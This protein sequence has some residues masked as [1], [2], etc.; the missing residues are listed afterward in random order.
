[1]SYEK[2]MRDLMERLVAMTPEPPPYPGEF[3]ATADV[4]RRKPRPVLAFVGAAVLVALLAIP[5]ILLMSG[6]PGVLADTTTTTVPGDTTTA[7]PETTTT[8]SG[9]T[10]TTVEGETTTTTIPPPPPSTWSGLLYLV[11]TPE[12][13]FLSN[14]ALVPVVV[15]IEASPGILSEFAPFTRVLSVLE[16]TDYPERLF[17]AIPRDVAVLNQQIDGSILVV[18]MNEA[19]LAGAGGALAD[20]TMLNQLIYTVT[21]DDPT[22]EVLFTVNSQPVTAFGSEGLS[23]VDPVGREDFIDHLA[24]IFLTEPILES[25][26]V[27]TVAGMS[28]VF[29]AAMVVAVIDAV[30][31]TTYQAPTMAT[32]GSGEWGE[33][34]EEVPAGEITPGESSVRVFTHSPEDGSEI[35][36]VTV[37]IPDGG[38]W[39]IGAED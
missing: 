13:S 3:T 7:L 16:A 11:Q 8:V 24:L 9:E 35:D 14:P 15:E 28:N 31:E 17:N 33:Y 20:F 6:D 10:T 30:G 12:N 34:S 38:V 5:V 27:Y 36:I 23:L 32:S 39:R 2:R 26:G 21:Q 1:M 29:E 4:T 19:F 25:G 18:D 22:L 37:P